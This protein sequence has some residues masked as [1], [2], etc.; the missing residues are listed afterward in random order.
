MK[1]DPKGIGWKE[2]ISQMN[3]VG[4]DQAK[5]VREGKD[6]DIEV[7]I[8]L[9]EAANYPGGPRGRVDLKTGSHYMVWLYP[10]SG[11]LKLYKNPGWDINAGI[12]TIGA[13]KFKP[14]VDEYHKIKLSI[15]GSDIKSIMMTTSKLRPRIN[16]TNKVRSR[17][18]ARIGSFTLTISR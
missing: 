12:K 14:K 5:N 17:S 9:K 4:T 8:K 15:R 1:F 7:D 6:Y 2:A 13:G 10:A 11:E 3:F 18:A 16:P